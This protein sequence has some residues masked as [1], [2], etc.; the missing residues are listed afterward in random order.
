MMGQ[1][2][3]TFVLAIA[4]GTLLSAGCASEDRGGQAA[5]PLQSR[6]GKAEDF[7]VVDCLLP[8]Q[9]RQLGRQMTY[10][11]ARRAIKTSAGDCEIRGGE[12]VSLDR[13][14]Y[15]TALKVWLPLAQQGD[16]GAQTYVGEI[17]EKGLGVPPDYA[18]AAEWYRRAAENGY[19]RAAINLGNLLEQGLGAPKDPAQALKWYR[20]A[21]GLKDVNFEIVP[22]KTSEE[23]QQQRIQIAELRRELQAK[24]GELDRAQGELERLRRSLEERRSG[25]DADRGALARMRRELDELRGTSASATARIGELQRSIAEGEARVREKDRDIAALRA[26]IARAETESGAQRAGLDREVVALRASL[27]RA[28]AESSAQ[29]AGLERLVQQ[30]A[31]AG[32]RIEL[33]QVQLIEPEVV[34][35][36]RGQG[37]EEV[38]STA[39]SSVLL[40]G[41]VTG[42]GALKSFTVN[43]RDQPIDKDRVFRAQLPVV[44][45][46]TA[47]NRRIRLVAV[48]QNGRTSTLEFLM[49]AIDTSQRDRSARRSGGDTGKPDTPPRPK[50][51]LGNYHALVI[52]NNDYR[53]LPR[54]RT[55]VNDATDVARIL[56][57]RYR[58]KVKLLTNATRYEILSALNGLR[59]ELTTQ[60]NLLVYYAG[61]G[62]LDEKN[63]RG[64]WLPVDAEPENP[65][66]WIANGDVTAILNTM[67]VKQLLLVVDSCYSGTL[68]RS[69]TG[70]MEAG[71]T[72]A[73]LFEVIRKMAQQRS[74]MV[75][76]SGG[77]EPVLDSAGG[78]HS[79]FAEVFIQVLRDND[80]VLLGRE[81]FRR[82]QLRVAA[83]AERLTVPQ[84]PE[85]APIR[86]AGHEA[87]DF[88][89]VRSPES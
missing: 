31:A 79:A 2:G 47:A 82:L 42:E 11:T 51:S 76:S 27:A 20:R 16:P 71:M 83:M 4:A 72:Q 44:V 69:A 9:V 52:G 84:V 77:V 17:F 65:A 28:E 80:G 53:Q 58:F 21:A 24:Q 34:A 25:A 14:S 35:S 41:R 3:R 48:D 39:D 63:Q 43:Q 74:R 66:N 37:R 61:H 32:P 10:L 38:T 73:E 68:T 6:P 22:G 26:S 5:T 8:G 89:F 45:S 49:P 64:H 75:M 12:Y 7:L 13:A 88:V 60:D 50:L 29:R 55:A 30:A 15:A 57:E 87:G 18:A 33:L 56:G 85:Y 81:V 78:R 19:S 70:Q 62:F 54:L 46:D 86:F 59:Q 36:T 1:A 23:V 67:E 40:V